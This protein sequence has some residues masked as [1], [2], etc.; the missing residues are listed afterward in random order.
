[1][2]SR[3]TRSWD[4]AT[5]ANTEAAGLLGQWMRYVKVD[6]QQRLTAPEWTI[7]FKAKTH[8]TPTAGATEYIDFDD[9]DVHLI[10]LPTSGTTTLAFSDVPSNAYDEK[11]ATQL[12]VIVQNPATG[13][14]TL[15]WPAS[16]EWPANTEPTRDTT[17]SKYTIYQLLTM[18]GGT[19]W[20]GSMVGSKY[21]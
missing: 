13:S 7:S 4:I 6:F 12:T 14:C 18:D 15:A 20:W 11:I 16:V 2:A 1:M 17:A 3:Y 19:K 21:D 8:T 5:P 9:G 10:P